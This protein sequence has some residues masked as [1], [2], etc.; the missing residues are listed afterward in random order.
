[1]TSIGAYAFYECENLEDVTLSS[2]LKVIENNVFY[3]SNY[4][5]EQKRN[6]VL[7]ESLIS[8]GSS[9]F[10]YAEIHPTGS[11]PPT[12]AVDA[13]GKEVTV[14]IDKLNLFAVYS[15]ADV[16]KDYINRRSDI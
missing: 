4:Y 5:S 6:I 16:W 1:M 14:V 9:A 15:N 10:S 3:S 2:Q 13:F 8:I 12:L 7:P 11:V